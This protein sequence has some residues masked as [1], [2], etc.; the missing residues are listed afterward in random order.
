MSWTIDNSAHLSA[1]HSQVKVT[2]GVD[3]DYKFNAMWID[4]QDTNT[5]WRFKI[6]NGRNIWIGVSTEDRFGEC[7]AVKGIFYGGP[8]N[9][10]DGSGLVQ[11]AWGPELVKGDTVD[12]K[13]QNIS[14]GLTVEFGRNG[15][16]LGTAFDIKGWYYGGQVIRSIDFEGQVMRPIVSLK[17]KGDCVTISKIEASEFPT[18]VEASEFPTAVGYISCCPML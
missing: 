18:A 9:L 11:M 17:N 4:E 8:G 7:Y 1:H 15:L 3:V 2:K 14:D 16:Y 6:L 12:M 5:V 13:V 10:S